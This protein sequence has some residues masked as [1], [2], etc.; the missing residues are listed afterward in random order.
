[1]LS[2]KKVFLKFYL[3]YSRVPT[4]SWVGRQPKLAQSFRGGNRVDMLSFRQNLSYNPLSC[5]IAHV[6]IR[7]NDLG[8]ILR[9]R[10]EE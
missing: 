3:P 2:K 8:H 5:L 1:M 4:D 7:L 9:K 6:K 10:K